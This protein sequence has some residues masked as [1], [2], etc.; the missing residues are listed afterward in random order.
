MP[1]EAHRLLSIT[2]DRMNSRLRD[3]LVLTV[4]TG[5]SNRPARGQHETLH[6]APP[7]VHVLA[8]GRRG[9][10]QLYGTRPPD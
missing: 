6:P 5:P 9:Y 8:D 1:A 2:C 4:T 7:G 10:R 3:A